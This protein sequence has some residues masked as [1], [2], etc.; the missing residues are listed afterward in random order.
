MHGAIIENDRPFTV[1]LPT[2]QWAYGVLF[3]LQPLA[4]TK[5]AYRGPLVAQIDLTVSAGIVK[6]GALDRMQQLLSPM[7]AAYPGSNLIQIPVGDSEEFYAIVLQNAA[8]SG[9]VTRLS[10]RDIGAFT[11]AAESLVARR[12][13][14]GHDLFVILSP[15]KTGTQTIE[16]TLRTLSP[17]I[18]VRRPHYLSEPQ[19]EH[20][21]AMAPYYVG[22]LGAGNELTAALLPQAD[23]ADAVRGEIADVRRF[24]G[25]VAFITAFREPIDRAVSATFHLLPF[26][27]PAFNQL[28]AAGPEFVELL[29]QGLIASWRREL[30]GKTFH[31]MEDCLWWRCLDDADYY[32]AEFGA[33][34]GAD[35]R[36]HP[37]DH[38][39]GYVLF[40]HESNSVL[41]IRT[42]DMKRA[43][44]LALSELTGRGEIE[45][46]SVNI[47]ETKESGALYKDFLQHFS[48]PADLVEAIFV[49]HPWLTY[50]YSPNEIEAARRR[51]TKQSETTA[52]PRHDA[53]E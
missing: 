6:I 2:E 10:I 48:V 43:L 52:I 25:R 9:V 5:A 7:Q 26:F 31:G 45:L 3:P 4:L 50:F 17:A 49:R 12:H 37:F 35:L 21:R 13:N 11:P 38:G 40:E 53:A 32:G 36:A 39:R 34:T 1:S 14:L 28:Y 20:T 51:W 22:L 19:I 29:M 18:E 24:G 15:S 46:V 27:L 47:G 23:Y 16:Q 30:A 41:A 8:D 42:R 33:I 44:P